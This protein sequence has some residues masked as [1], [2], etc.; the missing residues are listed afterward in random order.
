MQY[1]LTPMMPQGMEGE[2][3]LGDLPLTDETVAR[4]HDAIRLSNGGPP[5][6]SDEPDLV[7]LEYDQGGPSTS[8]IARIFGYGVSDPRPAKV[9]DGLYDAMIAFIDAEQFGGGR[10]VIGDIELVASQGS[11]VWRFQDR[12]TGKTY[13][14]QTITRDELPPNSY[15][16]MI[17]HASQT[18]AFAKALNSLTGTR[19]LRRQIW[20]ILPSVPGDL[21]RSPPAARRSRSTTDDGHLS[22]R[23][24]ASCDGRAR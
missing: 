2:T 14:S 8:Q 17:S 15:V 24:P 21:S 13:E 3:F 18:N 7:V 23:S 22:P 11:F 12:H 1:L 16:T 5:F 6:V 19:L 4:L 20:T 9:A 10:H